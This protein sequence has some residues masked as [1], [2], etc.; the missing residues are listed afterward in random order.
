MGSNTFATV[1]RPL[2]DRIS[3]VYTSNP[4]KVAG[5]GE[6]V[7]PTDLPPGKLLAEIAAKGFNTV[8]LLGGAR[9]YT[10]WMQAGVVT[11]LLLTVEPV[12]FGAG[13][14]LFDRPLSVAL[15]LDAKHELSSQTT[16]FE[17]SVPRSNLQAASALA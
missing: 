6:T 7:I 1:N 4:E 17:Y 10:Q 14:K 3:Y 11:K 8:A 13:V 16:V 12:L 5:F 9:V 2:K 15:H